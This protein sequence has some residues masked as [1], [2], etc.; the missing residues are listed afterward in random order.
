MLAGMTTVNTNLPAVLVAG[1]TLAFTRTLADY[2]AGDGWTLSYVLTPESGGSL[3]TFD[4]T[5]DGD[6]FAISVA[7]ATTAG[8]A[9]GDY[10]FSAYVDDG[11]SRYTVDS[12]R[13]TI[14]PNPTSLSNTD[15]RT[16]NRKMLDAIR[17]HLE[18]NATPSQ[19]KIK[20]D[21]K[22]LE[23]F[24]PLELQQLER[25]YAGL[26]SAEQQR[27]SGGSGVY[28]VDFYEGGG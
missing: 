16:H 12:G 20:I 10:L 1:D 23:K 18:G 14:K 7:K 2:A 17:A 5:P 3:I 25:R 19:K 8:Y 9:A 28:E 13:I 27:E 6:L 11:T 24:S 15:L 21:D 4:S 26:V 22:E